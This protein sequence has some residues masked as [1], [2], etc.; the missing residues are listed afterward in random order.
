MAH[1]CEYCGQVC[2]CDFDDTGGLSQPDDCPHLTGPCPC[3][4]DD[5]DEDPLQ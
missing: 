3:L 5:D 1:E 4:E 2:Y